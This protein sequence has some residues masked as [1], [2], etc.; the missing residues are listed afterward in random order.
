MYYYTL[1]R[2]VCDMFFPIV[3]CHHRCRLLHNTAILGHFD[4]KKDGFTRD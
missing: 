1:E 4:E 3:Q 2:D